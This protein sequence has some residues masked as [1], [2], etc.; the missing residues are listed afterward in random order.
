MKLFNS[1]SL[2]AVGLGAVGI[3]AP[4]RA[5]AARTRQQL[6]RRHRR[7]RQDAAGA[8]PAPRRRPTRR[9]S[10][11][12][13]NQLFL[14][15]T[16][17]SGRRPRTPGRTTATTSTA[18]SRRR[19]RHGRLHASGRRGLREAGRRQQRHRQRVRSH[20]PRLHPR[21]RRR[22]RRRRINDTIQGGSF[23][24][25]LEV[26]G[27][28]DDP[29]QTNT[30]LSG[31][32]LVGGDVRRRQ[33]ADVHARRTTGRTAPRP[34]RPDLEGA[35]INNG[36]FVNGARRRDRRARALHPGR[37]SSRSRS[38]APSSRSITRRRTTS[39]T[40]RSPAS[41]D[42]EELVTGIEKVAGRISTQLCGGSTLDDIEQTI[43]QASDILADGTNK[44]GVP[45][46]AH[47]D[48]PR[49]HRQAHRQP[50]EGR[51]GRGTPAPDPC[52][53]RRTAATDGG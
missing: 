51:D 13:V 39:R 42:T 1:L 17:R 7:G 19:R 10:T 3:D 46:D 21:P 25:L 27:L 52:T 26:K 38:T 50:D 14:G 53:R 49:L 2:L 9:R 31:R 18:S 48:R 5:A 23:T 40:A 47:L 43:R 35:Y 15:E 37:R 20:G 8:P 34:D 33:E 22:P 4:R 29:K 45:C 16:D 41:L 30:G 36:T 28:T 24:I 44:A 32:L 6:E 12:A 11:F